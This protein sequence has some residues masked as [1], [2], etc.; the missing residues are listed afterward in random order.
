MRPRSRS[1]VYRMFLLLAWLTLG[2]GAWGY[3]HAQLGTVVQ[4]KQDGQMIC[5]FKRSQVRL[6]GHEFQPRFVLVCR[7][8]SHFP[9]DDD[10]QFPQFV[11]HIAGQR[12]SRGNPKMLPIIR[13]CDD[14]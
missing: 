9:A 6:Q 11:L 5:S 10:I 2:P 14:A 8:R 12:S 13:P 7:S 1:C 3:T 4:F